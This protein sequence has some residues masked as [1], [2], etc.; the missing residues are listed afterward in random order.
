MSIFFSL[1]RRHVGFEILTAMAMKS[2][3]FWDTTPCSPLK[4]N[5]RF[6]GTCRLHLRREEQA[7][8]E[9]IMK[10][11]AGKLCLLLAKPS[12]KPA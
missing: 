5:C 9:T 2:F 4:V 3:V 10:K 12:K 8:Q 7:K 1:E 11:V 6:R